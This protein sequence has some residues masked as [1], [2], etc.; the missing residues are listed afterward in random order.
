MEETKPSYY[1]LT[2]KGVQCDFFD[3]IEAMKLSFP[4]GLAL[5]Y[6][7]K[8]GDVQKQINDLD[9]CI[10]CIRKEQAFLTKQSLPHKYKIGDIVYILQNVTCSCNEAGTVG[11]VTA[12]ENKGVAVETGEKISS[13]WH[14]NAD[15]R[16][17]TIDEL[18]FRL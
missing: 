9:K 11:I 12:V 17:A 1:Q 7:R 3:V 14:N 8:K 16:L 2:I 13:N 18:D 4:L 5:K 6:F 10:E 15:V